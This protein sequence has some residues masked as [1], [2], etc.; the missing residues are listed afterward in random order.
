MRWRPTI[1]LGRPFGIELR[2]DGYVVALIALLFLS[3]LSEASAQGAP[4]GGAWAAVAHLVLLVAMLVCMM[5][6]EAGHALAARLRGHRPT[7]ILLSFVGLTFFEAKKARPSDEFWI[8]LAGPMVN[9]GIALALSPFVGLAIAERGA[10]PLLSMSGMA[11]GFGFLAWL[12]I[13]NAVM[14]LGNLTPGWPAD[15]ARAVRAWLA[16]RRGIVEGTARAVS[17]SHGLWLIMAGVSVILLTVLPRFQALTSTNPVQS[18]ATV[19][20]MYQVVVLLASAMGIYYGWAEKR[21]VARLGEQAAEE[22]GP[23]AEYMP[24]P[25]AQAP[26]VIDAEVVKPVTPNPDKNGPAQPDKVAELRETAKEG[27]AAGKVLWKVAKAS[28]K[29]VGWFAR[30]SFKMIGTLLAAKE[31]GKDKA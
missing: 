10:P 5:F 16:R 14:A 27:L 4:A 28:G 9:A 19:L 13:L 22:V 3:S 24:K 7:M 29:G 1:F 11:T 30:Q 6:H 18:S 25:R 23:A 12:S 8:A 21:R 2:L 17:L 26:R 31:K 15:G 20:V